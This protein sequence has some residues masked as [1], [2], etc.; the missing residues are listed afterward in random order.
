MQMIRMYTGSDGITHLEDIEPSEM[1]FAAKEIM[2]TSKSPTPFPSPWHTSSARQI[3][4]IRTGR[5][6][7]EVEDGNTRILGPGDLVMEEDISGKGHRALQVDD[8]PVIMMAVTL[9]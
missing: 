8:D 6:K 9:A 4:M 2:I 3:K 7:W 5:V 1:K